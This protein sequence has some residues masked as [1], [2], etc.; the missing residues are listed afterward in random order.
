MDTETKIRNLENEIHKMKID[1]EKVDEK[2]ED[3]YADIA[4]ILDILRDKFPEAARK[5]KFK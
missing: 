5:Y 2:V 4:V 1:I 3:H